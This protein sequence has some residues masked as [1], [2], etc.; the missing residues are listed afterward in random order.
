M[1]TTIEPGIYRENS[2][3]IRIENTVVNKKAEKTEFGQFM[4]FETISL[5]P[6][7]LL[8]I[9]KSMLTTEEVLWLNDYHKMVYDK[10]SPYLK[11]DVKK[12]LKDETCGI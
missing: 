9:E 10:L 6:I 7:S 1:I 3:G 5:C 4:S 12:W 2:H 8:P 11:E